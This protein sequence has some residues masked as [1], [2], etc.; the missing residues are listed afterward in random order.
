[1]GP[2]HH[3]TCCEIGSLTRSNAYYNAYTIV[4]DKAFHKSTDGSFGRGTT[5]KKGKSMSRVSVYSNENKTLPIPWWKWCSIINIPP[6]SWLTTPENGT[7]LGTSLWCQI[8][9]GWLLSSDDSQISIGMW[10]FTLLNPG[11]PSSPRPWPLGLWVHWMMT[12]S[13]WLI[14]TEWIILPIWLKSASTED[15]I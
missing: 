14:S 4:V 13:G 8:L 5:C 9:T 15:T 11:I 10:K 6:R 7:I 3:I 1:M 12:K 2:L